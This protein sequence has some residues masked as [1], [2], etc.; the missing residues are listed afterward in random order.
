MTIPQDIRETDDKVLDDLIDSIQRLRHTLRKHGMEPPVAID[1]DRE[2][3]R[4]MKMLRHTQLD[5]VG[6][7]FQM[8]IC[9]VAIRQSKEPVE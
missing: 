4:R 9:G 7:G 1:V 2:T 6:G 3:Y 8:K 5:F